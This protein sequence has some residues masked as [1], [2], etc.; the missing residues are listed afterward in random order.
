MNE[1]RNYK[2]QCPLCRNWMNVSD[3]IKDGTRISFFADFIF[4]QGTYK[5]ARCF[6]SISGQK[7]KTKEKQVEF[8]RDEN[9]KE[10]F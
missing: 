3:I 7:R 6:A 4:E 9:V 5:Q 2:V 10:L 1:N 8:K